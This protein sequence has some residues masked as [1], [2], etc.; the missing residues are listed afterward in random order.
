MF[1]L[2]TFRIFQSL[3]WSVVTVSDSVLRLKVSGIR[4]RHNNEI[5]LVILLF[6]GEN[7][8]LCAVAD[9]GG[10]GGHAPPRWRPEKNFLPVY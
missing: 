6:V 10:Q 7:L 3:S 5:Q 4:K 8:L 9:P 2:P 1:R